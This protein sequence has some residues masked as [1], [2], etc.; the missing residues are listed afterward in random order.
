M[1]KFL[2]IQA[3]VLVL[4]V[5][6]TE[7]ILAMGRFPPGSS[8]EKMADAR[9]EQIISAIKNEDKVSLKS[10]FSKK[11]LVEANELDEEI[12]RFFNFFDGY[13]VSWSRDGLAADESIRYGKKFIL[14]RF[15]IVVNTEKDDYSIFVMDYCIDT[16]DPDN[17]GVYTLEIKKLA[18]KNAWGAWQ[19]RMRAGINIYE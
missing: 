19:E 13:I 9:M 15:P 16:I 2:I 18:T 14:I 1:G 4:L 3:I 12:D 5:F 6:S 17:E 7:N 8:D 11:V 10:L